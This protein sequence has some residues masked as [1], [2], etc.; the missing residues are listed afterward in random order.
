MAPC[1][2]GRLLPFRPR[3]LTAWLLLAVI[4]ALINGPESRVPTIHALIEASYEWTE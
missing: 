4:C 1:L 2:L 3:P